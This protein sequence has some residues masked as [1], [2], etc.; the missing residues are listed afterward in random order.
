MN[1]LIKFGAAIAMVL[2]V[3]F[4]A[5]HHGCSVTAAAYELKI[6]E[7]NEQHAAALAD[8]QAKARA[9]EDRSAQQIAAIDRTHQER[10][11]HEIDSRDRTIAD[12]RAGTVSVRKR[13]TCPAGADQRVLDAPISTGSSDAAQGGGLQQADA[14]FLIR[15]ASEAD[16]AVTQLAACQAV[17]R[18]DRDLSSFNQ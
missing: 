11:T 5:Y 10:L 14:E 13:F 18:A 17:V 12:L 7:A 3:L 16:Q 1:P 15:F 2:V 6:T 9:T 8:L 4:G